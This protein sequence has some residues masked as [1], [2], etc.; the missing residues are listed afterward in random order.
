VAPPAVVVRL[1]ALALIA[2]GTA[3]A[4]AAVVEGTVSMPPPAA[5][6]AKPRYSLAA[7]YT[8]GEPDPPSAAVWLEGDFPPGPPGEAAVAQRHYQFSPGLLVVRRGTR[9]SFPN[10]DDE[11]HSV[12]SYS[13][14][15]RFDLGRYRKDEKPATLVFDRP[16]VVRLYCEIHEHMRGTV[17]VVDGPYYT[18]TDAAGRYRL[19]GIPAGRFTLR[20]WRDDDTEFVY[21]IEVRDGATLHVDLPGQ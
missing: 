3:V 16:G 21:P 12:F 9:I 13:K 8:V 19:E 1:L 14:A 6:E 11:Y 20:A 7:S 4:R 10:L 2:G 18:R 17:V 15:K 5:P